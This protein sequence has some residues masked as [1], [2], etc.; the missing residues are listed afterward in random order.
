MVQQMFEE[1]EQ[2]HNYTQNVTIFNL[3]WDGFSLALYID[4][5]AK[6]LLMVKN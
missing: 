6:L 5:G 4:L 1:Q 3:K 2:L